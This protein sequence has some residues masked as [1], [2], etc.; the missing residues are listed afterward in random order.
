MQQHNIPATG[1]EGTIQGVLD[2]DFPAWKDYIERQAKRSLNKLKIKEATQKAT[3]AV[4]PIVKEPISQ[5][6]S[7]VSHGADGQTWVNNEN[8]KNGVLKWW[9]HK[10]DFS[11]IM[12][13]IRLFRTTYLKNVHTQNKWLFSALNS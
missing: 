4:L 7:N 3:Q 6:S 5:V 1:D 9:R 2:K 12:G 10:S 8:T 13:F 11:E